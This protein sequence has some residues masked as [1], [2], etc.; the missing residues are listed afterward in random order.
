MESTKNARIIDYQS[1]MNA[2]GYGSK[3]RLLRTPEDR[4]IML[5]RAIREIGYNRKCATHYARISG[6]NKN[7]DFPDV[8][9]GEIRTLTELWNV[10]VKKP[11]PDSTI[12]VYR[13]IF[14]FMNNEKGK[15][16]KLLCTIKDEIESR[17]IPLFAKEGVEGDY[18]FVHRQKI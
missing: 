8:C 12:D 1:L 10:Y 3:V 18:I 15:T 7:D 11:L 4:L 5:H 16:R 14:D 13:E 17:Q 9:I 2:I 6:I